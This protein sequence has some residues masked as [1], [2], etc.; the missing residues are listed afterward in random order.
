VPIPRELICSLYLLL[1]TALSAVARPHP[2]IALPEGLKE[3]DPSLRFIDLSGDGYPDLIFSNAERYGVYLYNPTEKK[4][5]GWMLGWSHQIREGK[6]GDR[7]ALPSTVGPDVALHD[8]AM[9]VKGVKAMSYDQL[10]RPPAPAPRS[11][12]DSLKAIH[13]SPGFTVELAAAEPLVQDPIYI[14]WDARGRMWVVEMADYPFHERD[15]KVRSGRVKILESTR[16]DGVYDK[17]TV[18]LDHLSYPT[19]LACWKNGV[20]IASVPEVFYAEDTDNDGKADR[21]SVL[22]D[23]FAKGN[24]QHLLNGFSWGL[25]GWYYGGNGD[26]GGKVRDVSTG[27]VHDLS[28]RDFRFNPRTG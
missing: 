7:D 16:G 26:S 1:A 13:V 9:W 12:Q 8:G 21:R 2:E 20:I 11:P 6:P 23:G 18:F 22:F 24:P 3:N 25:D 5:L 28:G 19:G 10:A 14:D 4:N 27:K 15:G 17:V